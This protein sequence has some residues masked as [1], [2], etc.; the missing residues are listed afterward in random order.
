M[1]ILAELDNMDTTRSQNEFH[2]DRLREIASPGGVA[3][4]EFTIC[5]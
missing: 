5:S 3:M 1:K 2:E 4:W